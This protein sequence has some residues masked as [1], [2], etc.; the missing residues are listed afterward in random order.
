M[1][2]HGVTG[3]FS[4]ILINAHYAS[5]TTRTWFPSSMHSHGRQV[6]Y[7]WRYTD[8]FRSRYKISL[9]L[10]LMHRTYR[11]TD[12][13]FN[14]ITR[15]YTIWQF[16]LKVF[17]TYIHCATWNCLETVWKPIGSNVATQHLKTDQDAE[18]LTIAFKSWGKRQLTRPQ[19]IY[20][21]DNDDVKLLSLIDRHQILLLS[22]HN[23]RERNIKFWCILIIQISSSH[24]QR[25]AEPAFPSIIQ[26]NVTI[27]QVMSWFWLLIHNDVMMMVDMLRPHRDSNPMT[28]GGPSQS[29]ICM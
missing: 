6:L 16:K 24:R 9:E 13:L 2:T 14:A 27:V 28:H 1:H 3:W 12:K 26:T 21:F 15:I 18:I 23:K 22:I 25:L 10:D 4:I 17:Q 29:Y 7:R 5:R 11:M 19:I 20:Y 8:L